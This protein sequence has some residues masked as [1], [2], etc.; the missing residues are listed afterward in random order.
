MN[1]EEVYNT[2]LSVSR[3]ARNKPW[4]ARKDFSNFEKT[5]EWLCCKK[6]ELFFKKFPQVNVREFFMAPYIIYN[7]EDH[8]PLSFYNS[9]KAIGVYSKLRKQKLEES[10]DSES[11]IL[12]IKRTLKY[13]AMLCITEG[14][15]LK[16]YSHKNNGYTT[17]PFID[18]LENRVNIYVLI[19]LPSFEETLNIYC[20]Q[21]KQ[22][23]LRDLCN[24]IGKFKI[25]LHT[26]LKAKELIT[27]GFNLINNKL[28]TN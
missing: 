21:D 11:H 18:Y 15:T 28:N 14:I 7:D 27:N 25:K 23:F 9:Q 10:P 16:E 8:F 26:S 12:D 1:H 2:Y 19:S 17:Q 3:G 24:N 20:N 13:I 6:L 5:P 22:I 4:K